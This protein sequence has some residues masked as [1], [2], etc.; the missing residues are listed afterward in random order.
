LGQKY[1]LLESNRG[2]VTS[3]IDKHLKIHS[4]TKNSHFA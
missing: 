2:G 4:I 1:V 3:G